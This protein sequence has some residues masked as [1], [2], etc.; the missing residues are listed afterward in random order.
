MSWEYGSLVEPLSVA[1]HAVNL[2]LLTLMDTVV[3]VGA[4]TIVLLAL[5][6]AP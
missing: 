4:G 2:T 5:L 3:I 1:L 6:A